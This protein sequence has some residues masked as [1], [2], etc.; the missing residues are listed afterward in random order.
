VAFRKV[1]HDPEK[2]SDDEV[3]LAVKIVKWLRPFTPKQD[4]DGKIVCHPLV[5]GPFCYLANN[6]L[7]ALGYQDFT[8]RLS[9]MS[10]CGK[11]HP[12]PLSTAGICEILC[13][14]Q[15]GHY[16]AYLD[17]RVHSTTTNASKATSR[18]IIFN[19]F[20]DMGVILRLCNEHNLIFSDR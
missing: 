6:F 5:L 13:A 17:G 15:E 14:E 18:N 11:R 8:R 12:L 9:P 1:L 3:E 10:A 19:S 16:D 4:T 7:R 2:Y 20:F